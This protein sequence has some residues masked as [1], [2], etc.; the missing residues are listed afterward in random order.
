M[1][2]RLLK[3]PHCRNVM[4]DAPFGR[5]YVCG[6]CRRCV[7]EPLRRTRTPVGPTI[8]SPAPGGVDLPP[9]GAPKIPVLA[10]PSSPP[11]TAFGWTHNEVLAVVTEHLRMQPLVFVQ[12]EIPPD[13]EARVR[14]R[15]EPCL[16]DDEVLLAVHEPIPGVADGCVAITRH[17]FCWHSRFDGPTRL[18]WS[19]FVPSAVV[20]TADA[21]RV[22]HEEIRDV[23]AHALAPLAEVLRR[24]SG[25]AMIAT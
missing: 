2:G 3:C 1:D 20:I 16:N 9:L 19:S 5:I 7:V 12:P 11:Q 13:V 23:S 22:N 14:E 10:T 6:S 21:L 24:F 25:L 15:F 4:L 8:P 17:Q 18:A